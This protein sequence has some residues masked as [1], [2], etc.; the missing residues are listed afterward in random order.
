MRH[1]LCPGEPEMVS[2]QEKVS[3]PK[4]EWHAWKNSLQHEH[5]L[6]L[7][8][9]STADEY[10]VWRIDPIGDAPIDGYVSQIAPTME[11]GS[12]LRNRGGLA[13][14]YS[15]CQFDMPIRKMRMALIEDANVT[16]HSSTVSTISALIGLYSA[17]FIGLISAIFGGHFVLE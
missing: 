5:A 17:F 15:W 16:G 4:T 11:F 13:F 8:Y 10:V 1:Y 12:L 2:E 14:R 3:E 7:P 9:V 6:G